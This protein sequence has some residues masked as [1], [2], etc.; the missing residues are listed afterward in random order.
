MQLRHNLFLGRVSRQAPTL[1]QS[2]VTVFNN[3]EDF[4]YRAC[5][6]LRQLQRMVVAK[7]QK[8]QET[9][10]KLNNMSQQMGAN[11]MERD[12]SFEVNADLGSTYEDISDSDLSVILDAIQD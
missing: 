5:R 9:L 8:Y 2:L 11:N 7:D 4:L 3:D 12:I 6:E 1:T 10:I